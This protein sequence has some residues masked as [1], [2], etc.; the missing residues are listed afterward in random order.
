MR[1]TLARNIAGATLLLAGTLLS[2]CAVKVTLDPVKTYTVEVGGSAV[3]IETPVSIGSGVYIG[4]G[5]VLTA[6]HVVANAP[7]PMVDGKVVGPPVVL[8]RSDAG[9]VQQGEILWLNK[10]Y[11]IAAVRP[12]NARRFT[13]AA[14]SC[15]A[16]T[17][18]EEVTA[19]GNPL[20]LKFITM[21]GYAA[22]EPSE[23]APNWKSAFVTDISMASGMSGGPAFDKFGEV[24]GI[25]VGV[26]DPHGGKD[27]ATSG[28]AFIVPGDAICG[29]LGRA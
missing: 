29:L 6:A 7:A 26:L 21:H 15:R 14:L 18:G 5:M 27:G 25:N 2:A 24:V 10:E 23:Y 20:G 1:R 22:S 13:A 16:P 17:R 9:D 19:E 12:A 11:D 4:N 8:L 28:F 3:R